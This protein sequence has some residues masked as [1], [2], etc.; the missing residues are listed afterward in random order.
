[1]SNM[2]TQISCCYE[3]IFSKGYKEPIRDFIFTNNKYEGVEFLEDV[4]NLN[5]ICVQYFYRIERVASFCIHSLSI[6]I[7]C[8]AQCL[9]KIG[10]E[11][12]YLIISF[13]LSFPLFPLFRK[14]AAQYFS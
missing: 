4:Y 2:P 7:M 10:I 3:I 5:D 11:G 6:Y 1:M 9:V 8:K 12:C 13:F 14:C